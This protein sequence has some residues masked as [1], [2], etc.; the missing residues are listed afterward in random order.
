MHFGN[1]KI[2]HYWFTQPIDCDLTEAKEA[3]K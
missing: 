3:M 2:I 1:I